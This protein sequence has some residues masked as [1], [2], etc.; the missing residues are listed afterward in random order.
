MGRINVDKIKD[1]EYRYHETDPKNFDKIVNGGLKK[2]KGMYGNGVYFSPQKGKGEASGRGLVF[3]AKK[4]ELKKLGYDEFPDE[5]W[6]EKDVPP[7]IL[8]YEE[9]GRWITVKGGRHVFIK[10]GQTVGEAIKGK[11]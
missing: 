3:R 6:T 1:N 11:R 5:G 4:D 8:E 2:S 9:D 7:D 10:K